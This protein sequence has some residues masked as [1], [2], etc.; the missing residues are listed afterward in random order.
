MVNT[1]LPTLD[2][3]STLALLSQPHRGDKHASPNHPDCA[4]RGHADQSGAAP[5]ITAANTPSVVLVPAAADQ[6]GFVG[7]SINVQ[8]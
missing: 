3:F 4:G 8:Q 5:A 6:I 7:S 1:P 2:W